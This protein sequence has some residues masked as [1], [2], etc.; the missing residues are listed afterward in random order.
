MI[1][2]LAG[3][4]STGPWSKHPHGFAWKQEFTRSVNNA[5]AVLTRSRVSKENSLRY[6]LS[7]G[8]LKEKEWWTKLKCACGEE[9]D[10][11]IPLLSVDSEGCERATSYG[12]SKAFARFFPNKCMQC[13]RPRPYYD[14][15]TGHRIR[16][17]TCTNDSPLSSRCSPPAFSSSGCLDLK[18]TGPDGIYARFL[19]ECTRKLAKPLCQLFASSTESS[20]KCGRLPAWF[21]STSDLHD[22]PWRIIAQFHCWA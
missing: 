18:A 9:R 3:G 21:Q 14:G 19:K 22:P 6:S 8:S 11:D 2:I 15:L 7:N 20:H 13:S 16:G 4:K 5:I 17:R 12:K 1:L 10:T